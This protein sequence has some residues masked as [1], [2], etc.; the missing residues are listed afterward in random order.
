VYD[1][2]VQLAA[3]LDRIG[4]K[5][6]TL[7]S[8]VWG[9]VTSIPF[10]NLDVLAR[11]PIRLDIASVFDKLVTRRRGGYCFEH[12]TLFAAALAEL[13]I[14]SRAVA[15]R[16]TWQA[17]GP[18]PRTHM[19][20]V[21][22]D[23]LVDVGFGGQVPT[24]PVPFGGEAKLHHNTFALKEVADT[25]RLSMDGEVLY[26]FTLEPQE[27]IDF[28]L[29]NHWTATHPSSRFLTGPR[30]ALTT[31]NGRKTLSHDELR[32]DGA[33]IHVEDLARVLLDEFGI[34]AP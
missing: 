4:V 12:N 29:A 27:P 10:E 23:Q 26:E 28:E 6:P 22:G 19:A 24:G 5:D 8:L 2:R 20:L 3:Y 30:I 13:G 31:K 7:E 16:V 14:A 18:M 32:K 1:A 33:K 15:A 21:V 34:V 9:H 11:I 17:T 25:W